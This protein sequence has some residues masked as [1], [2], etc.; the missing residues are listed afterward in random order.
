MS[1]THIKML[2]TVTPVWGICGRRILGAHQ[3][4]NT[5]HLISSKTI[6]DPVPEEGDGVPE[7]KI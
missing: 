3:P 6:R 4:V 5:A 2:G 7:D 1:R